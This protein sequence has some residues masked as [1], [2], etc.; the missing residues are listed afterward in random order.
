MHGSSVRQSN[1]STSSG[2]AG[3]AGLR[4]LLVH[5]ESMDTDQPEPDSG[6]ASGSATPNFGRGGR[7]AAG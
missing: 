6:V 2:P 4:E 5:N 7:D 1:G 3:G